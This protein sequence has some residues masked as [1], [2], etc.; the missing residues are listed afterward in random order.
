MHVQ[1]ITTLAVWDMKSLREML[2][3]GTKKFVAVNKKTHTEPLVYLSKLSFGCE[4]TDEAGL[5]ASDEF[6]KHFHLAFLVLCEQEEANEIVSKCNLAYTIYEVEQT[7]AM[8]IVSA[9]LSQWQQAVKSLI[10]T[11]F[12]KLLRTEFN[13]YGLGTIIQ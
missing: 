11:E 13:K 8:L 12:C 9:N 7:A 4:I 10:G 6:L 1:R 3:R 5:K 2:R